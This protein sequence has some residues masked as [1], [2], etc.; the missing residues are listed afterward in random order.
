M[1]VHERVYLT[2]SIDSHLVIWKEKN[3]NIFDGIMSLLSNGYPLPS[4]KGLG[5]PIDI[6]VFI[7]KTSFVL[8][9]QPF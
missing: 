6:F 4:E 8:R 3:K 9:M 1:Q 7:I 5:N 2:H